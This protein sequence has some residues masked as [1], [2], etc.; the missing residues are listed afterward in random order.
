MYPNFE[1]LCANF[2]SQLLITLTFYCFCHLQ[3]SCH[4]GEVFVMLSY[5]V[6]KTQ[7]K[8]VVTLKPVI[9]WNSKYQEQQIL[10]GMTD[11]L[12][13]LLS[14]IMPDKN[15]KFTKRTLTDSCL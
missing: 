1:V 10:L 9:L 12:S 13:M 15:L 4:F 3:A 2:L 7:V 11:H 8:N 5:E 14:A 6:T